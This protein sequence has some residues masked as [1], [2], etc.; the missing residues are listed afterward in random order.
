MKLTRHEII[1]EIV[2]N[3]GFWPCKWGFR[4]VID[5]VRNFEAWCV[6]I[7]RAA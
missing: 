7:G 6:A 5:R 4:E 3:Q 2:V 1:E